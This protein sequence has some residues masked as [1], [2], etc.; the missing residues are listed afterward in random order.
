MIAITP[1]SIL[2]SLAAAVI[3]FIEVVIADRLIYPSMRRRH[4]RKKVTGTHGTDPS[5]MMYLVRFQSLVVLPLLGF[6]FG[7]HVFGEIVRS[8]IR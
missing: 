4:E 6:L 3:G 5:I 1:I 8:M 2:I 7:E